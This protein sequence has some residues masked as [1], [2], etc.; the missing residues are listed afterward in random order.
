MAISFDS[1]LGV[2]D[3][4]LMLRSR[5]SEILASNLA[6]ADTPGYKA[7]DIDFKAAMDNATGNRS[8]FKKGSLKMATS[9]AKH[10]QNSQDVFSTDIKYR[11]PYQPSLDGNSVDAGIE[12]TEFSKNSIYYSAS[13]RFL[14]GKFQGLTKAIKGQ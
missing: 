12:K 10:I 14:T 7:K 5:R 6:N 9:N 11:N 1:Y 3:D 4:A 2:H 13:L 8:E